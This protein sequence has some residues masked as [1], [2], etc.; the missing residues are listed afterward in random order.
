MQPPKIR[1]FTSVH[2]S[3]SCSSKKSTWR[4]NLLTGTD[5]RNY[6][7]S[8]NIQCEKKIQSA[9]L[10]FQRIRKKINKKKLFWTFKSKLQ[11]IHATTYIQCF[12]LTLIHVFS[13]LIPSIH[14]CLYYFLILFLFSTFSSCS[15]YEIDSTIYNAWFDFITT[16]P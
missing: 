8:T 12:F 9:F 6:K 15:C 1:S 4:H 13:C 2:Y 7:L 14:I 10:I 11:M 16:C 3:S 5:H